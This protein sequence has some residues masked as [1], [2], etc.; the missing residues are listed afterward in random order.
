[1]NYLNSNLERESVGNWIQIPIILNDYHQ[2]KV[3]G[4]RE[5]KLVVTSSG[6]RKGWRSKIGLGE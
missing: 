3:L 6:D 1:M 4:L 2:Q 5:N